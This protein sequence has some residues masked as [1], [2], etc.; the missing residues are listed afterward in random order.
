M[1]DGIQLIKTK[2][3]ITADPARKYIVVSAPGKRL[4]RRCKGKRICFIYAKLTL[5]NNL[6]Y[7]QDISGNL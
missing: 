7:E 1:A 6:P 3:I 4:E 2:N 5:E